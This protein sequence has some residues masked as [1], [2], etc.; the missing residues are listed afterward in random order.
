MAK[1]KATKKAD[2]V[3]IQPLNEKTAEFRIRGNAPYVQNRFSAKA[4]LV[5][6]TTQE[7]GSKSRKGKKKEPKNFQALYRDAMHKDVDGKCGIPA[8]SFRNAMI[9]ACRM[10]GFA[11]TRAKLSVFVQ[12][13]AYDEDGT[14]LIHFT[15]GKPHYHESP[16]RIQMTT[17]IRAR[18]MWDAGWEA[19]VRVTFDADQFSLTDVAN[20]LHRVGKQVGI[21][22]GRPD[23]RT[24]CGMGWGTFEVLEK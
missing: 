2:T 14:P 10:C 15:K 17:D 7:E 12:A 19:K 8:P 5:M 21:G 3:V 24:S 23:S 18:A 11:M 4:R 13:D 16:V 20:L 6:R 9:S 1:K 22:E